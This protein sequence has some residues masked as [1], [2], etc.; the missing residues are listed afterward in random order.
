[1]LLL[2]NSCCSAGMRRYSAAVLEGWKK[3][4]SRGHLLCRAQH[5]SVLHGAQESALLRGQRRF[6]YCEFTL[7]N[8]LCSITPKCLR[9]NLHVV[10][11]LFVSC[12]SRK[13]K[14][15]ISKDFRLSVILYRLC[16]LGRGF[17][18]TRHGGHHVPRS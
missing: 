10:F 12:N 7:F 6:A 13:M 8:K 11:F 1:M 15:V 17:L 4:Q 2:L 16:F 18:A 9:R 3:K 5:C 14:H